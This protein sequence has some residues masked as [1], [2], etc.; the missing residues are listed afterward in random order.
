MTVSEYRGVLDQIVDAL[1]VIVR[2][3]LVG[4]GVPATEGQR[5]DVAVSLMRQVR[6]SRQLTHVAASRYLY[7][8]GVTPAMALPAPYRVSA[9]TKTLERVVDLDSP[10]NTQDGLQKALRRHAEQ[11]ARQLVRTT[12][13]VEGGAWARVLTGPTSCAFCAML[14]S[15]GPVYETQVQAFDHGPGRTMF[16]GVEIDAYHDG[17]DCVVVFVPKGSRDWEGHTEWRKLRKAWE[18]SDYDGA[19]RGE[20]DNRPPKLVF[21]SWWEQQV[22][23]SEGEKFIAPSMRTT[24]TTSG[25]KQAATPESKADIAARLLPGLEQ[26]LADLRAKGL[27][28]DDPKIVWHKR[29]IAELRDQADQRTTRENG[30]PQPVKGVEEARTPEPASGNDGPGGPIKPPR[31]IPPMPGS[32]DDRYPDM[33][34]GEPA[35]LRPSDI[36][37]VDDADIEHVVEVHGN[38]SRVPRKHKFPPGWGSE[39]I[40][41]A[42]EAALWGDTEKTILPSSG[43]SEIEVRAYYD[44]VIL[45]VAVQRYTS[46]WEVE[47][48][49]PISGHGVFKLDGN[50]VPEAKPLNPDDLRG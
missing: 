27:P 32:P 11:P 10:A 38:G 4:Q 13:A 47:T 30:T 34:N 42:I 19:L 46:G 29:R 6:E 24:T 31:S 41:E 14:A 21:R 3:V 20:D 25:S 33:P 28:E 12:A 40:R 1:R 15:R 26:S 50:G 43:P 16:A 2:A 7:E 18:D 44:G 39:K 17:C 48:A 35:P 45:G 9:V 22:R 8:Q 23:Q 49:Y 37:H 36:N 5:H